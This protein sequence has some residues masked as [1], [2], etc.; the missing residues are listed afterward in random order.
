MLNK[1]LASFGI[2]SA[3]V[4]ARLTNNH[5][6]MGEDLTGEIHIQGGSVEQS[7]SQIYMYLFTY[8]S[9][10]VNDNETLHK[11]V[12]ASFRVSD[13]LVISPGEKKILPFQLKVPYH[14]PISYNKQQVYLSTGLDI[15]RAIDPKDLDPVIV[16]PDPLM[17]EVLRQMDQMGFRHSYESGKCKH[18]RHI[19]RAVPFVQEFEFKPQGT[20][21][22]R[23]DEI[24]LIF[25]VHESGMDILMQVDKR[26]NS[27]MG[28]F[29]EALDLDEK[30]VRFSVNRATGVPANLIESKIREALGL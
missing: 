10:K 21:R 30:Y 6:R 14:T 8:Y 26:A 24:E 17:E 5:V 27:I 7:I 18:T 25:D 4:D 19:H 9:R 20:F 13:T 28:I 23:L 15:E 2:G 22:D 12:L 3:K 11:E 16:Q 1:I 29:A